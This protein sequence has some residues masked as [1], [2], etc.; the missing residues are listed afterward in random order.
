[1]AL[2]FV[3]AAIAATPARNGVYEDSTHG[4]I[5]AFKGGNNPIK[6]LNVTCHG[7]VWVATN[8]IT[9]KSGKFSYSGPDFLAKNGR[10]TKKTGTM[11]ASGT[12]KSSKLV[13]GRAR[14]G[15]C[16]TSYSASLT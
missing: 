10:K 1:V 6:G 11:T 8:F 16:S 9:V 12:F 15:G 4:V 3:A 13:T 7:K 14:A 5:V 2:V